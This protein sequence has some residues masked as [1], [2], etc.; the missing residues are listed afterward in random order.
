MKTPFLI[1]LIVFLSAFTPAIGQDGVKKR[2]PLMVSHLSEE[3]Q[4]LL[5]RKDAPQ[6]FFL[7]KIICFNK[8]CRAY[9]GWRKRQRSH[10]FKGYKDGGK[11]PRT[12]KTK[13]VI[14]PVIRKDTVVIQPAA[15]IV[16]AD[17]VATIKEQVFVLDEVLFAIN[18]ATL[19]SGFTYRLDSL[20]KLLEA[21]PKVQAAI[22]G[23][24]DNTGRESHN[25]KLSHD[26]AAAV[27]AYLVKNNISA[28]RVSFEGL[29][30]SKPISTNNTEEGRRKNRRVEILLSEDL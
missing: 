19:N 13:P 15:P 17:T 3:N 26:R 6:H 16:Q 22:S 23:H 1:L 21:H 30:S 5:L 14:S 2:I 7:T 20:V 29:G 4:A 27:A 25:L 9:I 28:D 12:P 10:R 24:T 8:K 18:S 11:V